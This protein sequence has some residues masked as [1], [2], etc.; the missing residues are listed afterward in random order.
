MRW[1]NK[2][3]VYL[4]PWFIVLVL[5]CVIGLFGSSGNKAGS[6]PSSP[7]DNS[8]TENKPDGTTVP[9][10]DPE[11]PAPVIE[12]TP[13]KVGTLMDDL[14]KNPLNASKTYK[15]QYVALTGRLNVIDSNG[16]Y[17][18]IVDAND[19]W[20]ILGVQCN[21]ESD[22]QLDVISQLSIGD[23]IVVSGQIK[24]VGEVLGYYLDIAHIQLP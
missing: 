16:S 15:D 11:S 10:A 1:K 5:L 13:Y 7:V 14:K 22:E 9:E 12:Y 8:I 19:E 24:D 18:S 4:R 2:K 17:I 23:V 3:P 20:A 6:D 21:V